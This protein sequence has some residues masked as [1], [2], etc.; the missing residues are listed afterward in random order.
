MYITMMH[1]SFFRQNWCK[2]V[3]RD[4]RREGRMRVIQGILGAIILTISLIASAAPA[5]TTLPGG[6]RD[7]HVMLTMRDGKKLSTYLYFPAGK[8]PWPVIYQERYADIVGGSN[9][10]SFAKLAAEGYVVA[11][12]NFRGAQL[13]EGTWVGYRAL[14]WGELQDGYDSVEW[15]AAQPWCTGKVGTF[16][17]SQA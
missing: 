10:Q 6:V 1:P 16:G 9:R 8:G 14:G 11:I 12:Q 7:E 3:H 13:S 2:I 17:S 5:P 4:C 15:L